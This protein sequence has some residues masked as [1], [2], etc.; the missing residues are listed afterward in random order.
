M[1]KFDAKRWADD[2]MKSY[3]SSYQF[4]DDQRRDIAFRRHHYEEILDEMWKIFSSGT[5][6]QIVEYN[7]QVKTIKD[8]GCKV[9][10]NSQGKHKIEIGG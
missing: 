6:S 8:C 7:K 1:S 4:K 5:T 2:L 9:F 3:E 10:R